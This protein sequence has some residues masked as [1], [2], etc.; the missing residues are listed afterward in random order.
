[1]LTHATH[2]FRHLYLFICTSGCTNVMMYDIN[3]NHTVLA[4]ELNFSTEHDRRLESLQYLPIHFL[5]SSPNKSGPTPYTLSKLTSTMFNSTEANR[6][7]PGKRGK[8]GA[9]QH[10]HQ[11]QKSPT[12]VFQKCLRRHWDGPLRSTQQRR[13]R[14]NTETSQLNQ[15]LQR[16]RRLQVRSAF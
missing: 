7:L 1:M 9:Y 6:P 3:A 16:R 15:L 13:C 5:F 2:L 12:K 14:T 11:H 8:C 10:Q 4:C